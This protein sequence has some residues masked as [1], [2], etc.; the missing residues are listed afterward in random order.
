MTEVQLKKW[1]QNLE[2]L[3]TQIHA[4]NKFLD[5]NKEIAG[6]QE[7]S[8]KKSLQVEILTEGLEILDS[9]ER[10][11]IEIH[12]IAKNTWEKTYELYEDKW[13]IQNGRSIRTL[14]R[15]QNRGI[16]KLLEFI[17]KSELDNIF[18]DL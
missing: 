18:V 6:L 3:K 14:K 10:F 9:K 7:K 2:T 8:E 16:N 4:W 12:L 5:Y 17:K 1:L 13:G 15:M 11:V